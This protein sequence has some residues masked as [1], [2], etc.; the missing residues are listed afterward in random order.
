MINR[1]SPVDRHVARGFHSPAEFHA[2]R[3][4]EPSPGLNH[5]T[6]A[7]FARLSPTLKTLNTRLFALLPLLALAPSSIEA[8]ATT[9]PAVE[10]VRLADKVFTLSHAMC[11]SAA[12]VGDK[13]ILLI[14]AGVS[15]EE[16]A[17]RQAALAKVT[18]KPVRLLVDTH[19]PFDHDNG[20]ETFGGAAAQR[21]ERRSCSHS[22]RRT[23]RDH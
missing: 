10:A 20:N 16:A 18:T 7:T 22:P 5:G 23:V 19:W 8:S 13:G 14:D 11:S 2:R 12:L 3:D 21:F 15:A 9:P 17:Q 4:C 6:G 1:P